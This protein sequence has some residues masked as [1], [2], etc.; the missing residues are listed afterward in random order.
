MRGKGMPDY[1]NPEVFGDFI[2]EIKVV[3][4]KNLT[5]EQKKLFEKLRKTEA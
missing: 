4:P 1:D 2:A 3:I 5:E